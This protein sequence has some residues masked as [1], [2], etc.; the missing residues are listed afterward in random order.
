MFKVRH[1]LGLYT[2]RVCLRGHTMSQKNP[3]NMILDHYIVEAVLTNNFLEGKDIRIN[4]HTS[5]KQI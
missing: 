2:Q 3:I 5:N 1:P 4:S